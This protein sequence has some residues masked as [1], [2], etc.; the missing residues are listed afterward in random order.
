MAETK[1]PVCGSREIG[2]GKFDGYAAL[3]PVGKVFST[4]SSVIVNLCTD[5]GT[6]L[7]MKVEKPE[8]FKTPS[9]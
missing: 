3:K 7:G 2:K 6:I 5:C 1:C 4:G 8:K 9:P